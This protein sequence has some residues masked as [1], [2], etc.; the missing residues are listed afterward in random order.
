MKTTVSLFVNK[1]N[2]NK[3][4]EVHND[5]QYHNSLR[6][7]MFWEKTDVKNM[8]GDPYLRRWKKANISELLSDYVKV[9]NTRKVRVLLRQA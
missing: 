5:G 9:E 1:R 2:P 7:F 6:Q 4:I 8:V 3:Y